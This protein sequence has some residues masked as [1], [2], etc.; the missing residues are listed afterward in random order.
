MSFSGYQRAIFTKFK[1]KALVF[2]TIL[3]GIGCTPALLMAATLS[4]S[5]P[6]VSKRIPIHFEKRA[7]K[8][9]PYPLVHV[10][11]GGEPSTMILDTG[12]TDIVLSRS[13]AK[14]LGLALSEN[15]GSGTDAAGKTVAVTELV[16][17]DL[18]IEGWGKVTHARVLVASLPKVFDTLGIAGVFSPRRLAGSGESVV[19]DFDAYQIS[20]LPDAEALARLGKSQR[21]KPQSKVCRNKTH[22]WQYGVTAEINGLPARLLFDTGASAIS[23]HAGSPI[24]QEL[25][26]AS[27]L[28]IRTH[29]VAS[30]KMRTRLL[31][32]V[33]LRAGG[34]T[35]ISDIE[36][37]PGVSGNDGCFDG[38]LGMHFLRK[39]TLVL[40]DT[41]AL[42][43][44]S[45]VPTAP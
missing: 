36:I 25:G 2:V 34:I 45:S 19:V 12:S 28:G 23:I 15:R 29:Y 4:R 9:F 37:V 21:L 32:H 35:T 11:L 43:C 31:P 7:G 24:A 44:H 5:V 30:G 22:A 14:R 42:E 18:V 40:G 10:T 8:P 41:S 17:P 3:L 33:H 20:V 6:V 38:A 27:K 39:C 26:S 1:M 16:T 13:I